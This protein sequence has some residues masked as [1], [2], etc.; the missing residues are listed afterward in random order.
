MTVCSK[1]KSWGFCRLQALQKIEAY[2][3]N[4]K[5]CDRLICDFVSSLLSQILTPIQMAR[6]LVAAYPHWPDTLA[7]STYIAAAAGKP[8]LCPPICNLAI[9]CNSVVASC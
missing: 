3:A 8:P 4:M 5:E 1:S 2:V 9:V 7:I 6:C